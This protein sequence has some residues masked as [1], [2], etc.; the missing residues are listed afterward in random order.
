MVWGR[1]RT[2]ELD[3]RL[4]KIVGELDVLERIEGRDRKL[5]S[6]DLRKRID[7]VDSVDKRLDGAVNGVHV[8]LDGG[9]DTAES[10]LDEARDL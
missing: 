6:V 7:F 4:S 2:V 10:V 5:G 8:V 3:Q 9:P 1:D